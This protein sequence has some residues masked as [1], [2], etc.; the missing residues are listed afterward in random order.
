MDMRRAIQLPIL[1]K[2]DSIDRKLDEIARTLN[3]IRDVLGV[4]SHGEARESL[5]LFLEL[6]KGEIPLKIKEATRRN[7]HMPDVVVETEATVYLVEA[8]H[9]INGSR[10]AEKVVEQLSRG[11]VWYHKNW[12]KHGFTKRDPWSR[13][14]LRGNSPRQH[15]RSFSRTVYG[16]CTVGNCTSPGRS[17]QGVRERRN[18]KENLLFGPLI[19]KPWNDSL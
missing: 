4:S 16:C 15:G 14:L 12:K 18:V 1:Q 5:I 13:W 9:T 8:K 7:P 10:E 19:F 3:E 11:A 17:M 2:L 6:E